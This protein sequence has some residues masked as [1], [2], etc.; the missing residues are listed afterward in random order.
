MEPSRGERRASVIGP[1]PPAGATSAAAME[2]GASRAE[3]AVER[4]PNENDR[5]ITGSA[6]PSAP[7][8]DTG[9]SRTVSRIGASPTR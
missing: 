9:S 5:V 1:R 4:G 8:T 2:S 6:L 7:A 3:S